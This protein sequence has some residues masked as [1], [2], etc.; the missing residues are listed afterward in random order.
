MLIS[1]VERKSASLTGNW[2]H[3]RSPVSKGLVV[4]RSILSW[5]K[6]DFAC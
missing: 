3:R 6:C 2:F 4:K 1:E 5:E